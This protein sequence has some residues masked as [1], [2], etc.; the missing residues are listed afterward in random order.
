[1]MNQPDMPPGADNGGS[2][3][4]TV[5]MNLLPGCKPGDTYKVASVDQGE[6][7]MEHMPGAG[8]DSTDV[9]AYAQEA[10]GA[11]PMEG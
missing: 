11:V 2:S 10:K 6:V 1:M 9:G 8:D 5:P 3:L 7:Q 4:V